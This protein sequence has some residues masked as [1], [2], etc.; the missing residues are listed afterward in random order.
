MFKCKCC[1]TLIKAE[2][3]CPVCGMAAIIDSEEDDAFLKSMVSDY[4]KNLFGNR[5]LCVKGYDY[6][7]SDN[8]VRET[9]TEYIERCNLSD[10]RY[11]KKIFSDKTFE[12]IPSDKAFI[13]TAV[14]M[15]GGKKE[16]EKELKI[17]PVAVVQ[18]DKIGVVF[19]EGLNVRLIV[20]DERKACSE[21]FSIKI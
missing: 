21:S 10:Y 9:N 17:K 11:G 13:V 12:S 14:I 7:L 5:K 6:E 2:A 8:D 16:S 4:L 20:N 15:N 3:S 19:E 18:R 1:N